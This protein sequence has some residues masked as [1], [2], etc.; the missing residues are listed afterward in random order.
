LAYVKPTEK[1]RR[2]MERSELR[3]RRKYEWSA[4]LEGEHLA[5]AGKDFECTTA[6]FVATLH[7]RADREGLVVETHT[8]GSDVRFEFKKPAK[9]RASK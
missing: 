7:R 1:E 2:G 4:W 9:R 3:V 8:E 6:S 5:K